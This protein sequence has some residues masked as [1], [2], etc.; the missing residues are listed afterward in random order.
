MSALEPINKDE[1]DALLIENQALGEVYTSL[2]DKSMEQAR[3]SNGEEEE[4]IRASAVMQTIEENEKKYFERLPRL[5]LS[6]CPFDE[7]PLI[8]TFDPFGFDGWWWR[9]D[10]APSELP[11]GPY[12]C[13][14]LGAV[15]IGERQPAQGTF[16]VYPGPEVPFVIPRLLKRDGMI[17]VISSIPMHNGCTA[18]PI[19]YFSDTNVQPQILPAGWARTNHVYTSQTEQS[20]WNA[21]EEVWDFNLHPWIKQGKNSMVQ[22]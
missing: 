7:K 8:R 10:A 14:L 9:S 20:G 3:N 12:F 13:A 15:H 5:V 6:C 16:D 2:V 22:C 4:F 18:Y 1:R 21:S 19:A 17:A 11:A